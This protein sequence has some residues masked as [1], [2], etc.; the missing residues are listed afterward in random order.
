MGR[1][2]TLSQGTHC[3]KDILI[4]THWKN[5]CDNVR[6]IALNH[7]FPYIKSKPPLVQRVAISSGPVCRLGEEAKPLLII[8]RQGA[9]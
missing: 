9:A 5:I 2:E 3:M 1:M 8:I 7:I 4:S 6:P